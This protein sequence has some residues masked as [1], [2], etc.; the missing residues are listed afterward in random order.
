MAANLAIL[1]ETLTDQ[2]AA[3]KVHVIDFDIG[4][5]CQY[6]LI[7]QALSTRV[8]LYCESP[9]I[10]NV[11]T[12]IV[13]LDSELGSSGEDGGVVVLKC[14]NGSVRVRVVGFNEEEG[15]LLQ[16]KDDLAGGADDG[17]V[18]GIGFLSFDFHD[19]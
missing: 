19:D 12:S 7:F 13:I 11:S 14:G 6:M 16:S 18:L 8:I 9:D 4:H 17:I 1:E 5:G 2:P 15:F 10:S 3:N